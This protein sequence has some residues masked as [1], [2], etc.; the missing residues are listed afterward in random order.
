[1]PNNDEGLYRAGACDDAMLGV[2]RDEGR[3]KSIHRQPLQNALNIHLESLWVPLEEPEWAAVRGL[4]SGSVGVNA[5]IDEL[6]GGEW[7]VVIMG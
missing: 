4:K 3:L 7:G 5:D 1:M 6:A 2:L